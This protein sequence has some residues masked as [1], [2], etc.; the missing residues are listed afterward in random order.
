MQQPAIDRCFDRRRKRIGTTRADLVR[1]QQGLVLQ[2]LAEKPLGSVDVTLCRQQEVDRI[3]L[4]VDGPVQVAPFATNSDLGLIDTHRA[5]MWPTKLTQPLLDDRCIGQ[6]PTIDGTVVDL[7]YALAEHLL[8][9]PIAE[10]MTQISTDCLH[11][12]TCLEVPVFEVI[13]R[14]ALHLFGNG[15]HPSNVHPRY[16]A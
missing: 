3:S 10:R 16:R 15:S 14:L 7:K 6:N 5:A 2:H 8:D 4:A 13:L 12:Q 11:N 9:T 1:R